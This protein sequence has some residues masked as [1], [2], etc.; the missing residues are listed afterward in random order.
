M[1]LVGLI[2]YYFLGFNPEANGQSFVPP[3]FDPIDPIDMMRM[4]TGN[5]TFIPYK[6]GVLAMPIMCTTPAEI[7]ESAAS[8]MGGNSS[9]GSNTTQA[10]KEL[11]SGQVGIG[12]NTTGQ[13]LQQ[14]LNLVVCIP[15]MMNNTMVMSN[16]QDNLTGNM[17]DG[18]FTR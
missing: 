15:S 18:M 10:I 16:T 14:A 8:M 5:T 11:A 9:A 17:K 12:Q 2:G 4:T 1:V 7:I 3:E 13:E 6:M